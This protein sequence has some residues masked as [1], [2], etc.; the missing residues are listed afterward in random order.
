MTIKQ[1]RIGIIVLGAFL[2]TSCANENTTQDN[3]NVEEFDTTG[4]TEFSVDDSRHPVS[5][6]SGIYTGTAGIKFFWSAGDRLWLDKGLGSLQQDKRNDIQTQI[7]GGTSKPTNAKFYFSGNF[8]ASS[9]PVRYTGANSMQDRVTIKAQQSQTVPNDAMHLGE[10]GDCATATAIRPTGSGRYQFMLDHKASYLTFVP[11]TGQGLI[12]NAKLMKIKVTANKPLAGDYAFGNNGFGSADPL[13]ISNPSDSIVLTLGGATGFPIPGSSTP[14]NKQTNAAIMVLAPGTYATLKVDYYLYDAFT[15]VTGTITKTYT[16]LQLIGGQNREV[17]MDLRVP[18]YHPKYTLWDAVNDL[19]H[20]YE[21]FQPVV[22]QQNNG[23]S[24]FPTGSTDPNQRWCNLTDNGMNVPV[25]AT[26][27]CAGCPNVNEYMWYAIKGDP[28]FDGEHLWAALGHLH[29]G[30]VWMKRQTAIIR[31][32][33]ILSSHTKN[34]T[35]GFDLGQGGG[36]TDYRS[37]DMNDFTISERNLLQNIP[38]GSPPPPASTL[39]DYFFLPGFG[40]Y[41]MAGPN[42]GRFWIDYGG[43]QFWSSSGVWNTAFG[44]FCNRTNIMIPGNLNRELNCLCV[45]PGEN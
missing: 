45:W 14:T 21:A 24:Y 22:N 2:A 27:N 12:Q 29:K 40:T 35:D 36:F 34:I 17:A 6:T 4:L 10:S 9:Y 39:S 5:R 37:Y 43:T 23:S 20:G 16:S 32:T 8:P 1:F 31:D 11:Y 28:R 41:E 42:K 33:P 13:P 18:V 25:L 26:N 19:W 7:N 3:K 38:V 30:G 44:M 15:N